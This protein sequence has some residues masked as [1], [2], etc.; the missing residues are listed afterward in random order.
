MRELST[1][2]LYKLLN[3][4]NLNINDICCKDEIKNL[5]NGWTIVNMDDTGNGGTHWICFYK[6]KQNIYFDSFA[7]VAPLQVEDVI[8]PYTMSKKAIQDL[9]SS[10][11]GWFCLFCIFWMQKRHNSIKDFNDF[12]CLFSNNTHNNEIQLNNFF[13]D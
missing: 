10:S 6:G 12:L 7:V 2:E 3:K 9:E 5:N 4:Y 11:C 1:Q 8:K 13:K